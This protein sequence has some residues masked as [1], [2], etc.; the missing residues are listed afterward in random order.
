MTE[1]KPNDADEST[2]TTHYSPFGREVRAREVHLAA[3]LG[4]VPAEWFDSLNRASQV[5][6]G[7]SLEFVRHLSGGRRL[8]VWPARACVRA[9]RRGRTIQEGAPG[10]AEGSRGRPSAVHPRTARERP[11]SVLSLH[12]MLAT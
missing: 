11:C 6:S 4:K 2:G 5:F 3:L 8:A 7:N 10:E 1:S 9:R 12:T